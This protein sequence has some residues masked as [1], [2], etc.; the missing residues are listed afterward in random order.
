MIIAR[1]VAAG[2]PWLP[3]SRHVDES[4]TAVAVSDPGPSHQGPRTRSRGLLAHRRLRVGVNVGRGHSRGRGIVTLQT[5]GVVAGLDL[6]QASRI[7]DATP[8]DEI[9]R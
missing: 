7:R 4:V 2:S 8:R 9:A 3:S 5:P 1:F 6:Y